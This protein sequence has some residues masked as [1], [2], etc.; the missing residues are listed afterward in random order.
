MLID[1]QSPSSSNSIIRNAVQIGSAFYNLFKQKHLDGYLQK[2]GRKQ[3]FQK[4]LQQCI[5]GQ[6]QR[7]L[8]VWLWESHKCLEFSN[9]KKLNRVQCLCDYL[10]CI[11][12]THLPNQEFKN[13]FT[14]FQ[15][16]SLQANNLSE[17]FKS[18]YIVNIVQTLVLLKVLMLC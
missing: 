12:E 3:S 14:H 5:S 2:L 1:F 6:G 7:K 18:N 4:G 9:K 16:K 13:S 8:S 17:F 15:R 11:Q 10:F